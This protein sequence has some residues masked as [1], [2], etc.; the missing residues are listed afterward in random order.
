MQWLQ[1]PAPEVREKIPSHRSL[2]DI[3]RLIF[4]SAETLQERADRL[5]RL[6]ILVMSLLGLPSVGSVFESSRAC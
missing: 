1:V 4:F 6:S 5:H 3:K 2:T